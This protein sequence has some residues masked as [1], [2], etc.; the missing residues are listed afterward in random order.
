MKKSSSYGHCTNN[1]RHIHQYGNL[2]S[3]TQTDTQTLN[4]SDKEETVQAS[5]QIVCPWEEKHITIIASQ[6]FLQKELQ[7][8]LQTISK[9]AVFK[10]KQ[11]TW[12]KN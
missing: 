11:S 2:T 8:Q 9:I 3:S 7:S 12:S 6:L 1:S 10:G 5:A 4:C